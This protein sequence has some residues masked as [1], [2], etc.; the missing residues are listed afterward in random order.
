MNFYSCVFLVALA[1]A[2]SFTPGQYKRVPD[3][4][5][6]IPASATNDTQTM[7]PKCYE[8]FNTLESINLKAISNYEHL[9]AIIT[10]LQQFTARIYTSIQEWRT[11][12]TYLNT[13]I[14]DIKQNSAQVQ[15]YTIVMQRLN[16]II[17][18]SLAHR[19][20]LQASTQPLPTQAP[21]LP[22][23]TPA[24]TEASLQADQPM[25]YAKSS[26]EFIKAADRAAAADSNKHHHNHNPTNAFL[27]WTFLCLFWSKSL[28][29]LV[30]I[31]C[32]ANIIKWKIR[33]YVYQL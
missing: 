23:A 17:G 24:A 15:N 33:S 21:T 29:I 22:P 13:L 12:Y 20:I 32:V 4:P 2:A 10:S 11:D 1:Q 27:D 3:I 28:A 9:T 18:Q 7:V 19:T 5:D 8:R 14:Q 6:D 26:F 16:A 31:H 30:P 25:P